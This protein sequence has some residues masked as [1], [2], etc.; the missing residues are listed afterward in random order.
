MD[1]AAKLQKVTTLDPQALT[2]EQA[3]EMATI[4]GARAVGMSKDIGS[5]E[6]GKR[7]DLVLIGLRE[8][9]AHPLYGVYSQLVYALKASDVRHV[10]V[11]GRLLVR[12]RQLLTI[13]L[14]GVVAK[15]DQYRAQI[16]RSIGSR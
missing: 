10:F 13:D 3:F 7:A 2:A 1:L 15:A 9:R 11:N 4:G 8:P 14:A 12:D 5:I 6:A 16:A